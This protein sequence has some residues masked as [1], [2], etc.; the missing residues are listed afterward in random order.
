[1][2]NRDSAKTFNNT[3]W[4]YDRC[5]LVYDYVIEN[6]KVSI[7]T[8]I[9]TDGWS[10]EIFGRNAPSSSYLNS[11]LSLDKRFTKIIGNKIKKSDRN[12]IIIFETS[13]INAIEQ[14]SKILFELIDFLETIKA[15]KEKNA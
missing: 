2:S 6:K 11:D 9:G 14:T 1:M 10:V 15:E 12:G 3:E 13:E 8:Y 7:D 5:C 4:I